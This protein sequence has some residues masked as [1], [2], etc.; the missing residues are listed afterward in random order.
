M[1]LAVITSGICGFVTRVES[2]REGDRC[3]LS[4]E[5]ECPNVKRL[6]EELRSVDPWGEITY[7]RGR[8]V[9]LT[10]SEKYLQ[11]PACPVPSG[12]IK[13]IEVACELAL[14]RA[15][16]IEVSDQ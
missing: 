11:H 15:A 7:R 2:H 8:P 1:A 12:I 16:H 5:T 6:A 10:L 3:V 13:A 9:T 4:F 14:P